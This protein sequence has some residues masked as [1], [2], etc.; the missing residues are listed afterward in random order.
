VNPHCAWIIDKPV[1]E[2]STHYVQE[3]RKRIAEEWNIP[4]KEITIGHGG[5]LDPFA[6]GV[7]VILSGLATRLSE[8]YLKGDKE[9]RATAHLGTSTTTADNTGVILK[10]DSKVQAL[11]VLQW[12][13]LADTFVGKD[14]LQTPPQYSAK[15]VDGVPAYKHA[16]AG[17]SITL[18]PKIQKIKSLQILSAS[19]TELE[20]SV[21]CSSGTYIRTL[22]EDLAAKA[23]TLAHLTALRRTK[24]A[25]LSIDQATPFDAPNLKH[26]QIPFHQ[27][28]QGLPVAQISST[29]VRGIFLGSSDAIHESL[30]ALS[31]KDATQSQYALIKH[32]NLTVALAHSVSGQWY[33][34]RAFPLVYTVPGTAA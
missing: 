6:S 7:L 16:R 4:F 24:K 23:G 28:G 29:L 3:I 9:Y 18:A 32:Q 21:H 13:T 26:S 20:F 17:E 8:I 30:A 25:G 27:L 1:G 34:Q 22:A 31:S 2:S 5:T 10:Q 11:T 15:K 12:Q 33:F 14:Y 19:D